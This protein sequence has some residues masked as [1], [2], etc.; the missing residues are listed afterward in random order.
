MRP[1]LTLYEKARDKLQIPVPQ[2]LDYCTSAGDTKLGAEYIVMEKAPG[3]EV[4][5]VWPNM[6]L[7][8]KAQ[9]VRNL[10]DLNAK[11][12]KQRFAV[13]GSM[14]FRRDLDNSTPSTEIDDTYAIGPIIERQWLDDQRRQLDVYRGPC[15]V[16][17]FQT[18]FYPKLT[19]R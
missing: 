17:C 1:S 2:V 3:V 5:H 16:L 19:N 15:T 8:A 14:Y 12:S 6:D 9:F 4:S 11:M 7:K 10:V 18:L 13:S